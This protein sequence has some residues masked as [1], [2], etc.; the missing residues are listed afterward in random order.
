MC[1]I[2]YARAASHVKQWLKSDDEAI[3]KNSVLT[4][5]NESNA[6]VL[7]L[8]ICKTVAHIKYLRL[9][10]KNKKNRQYSGEKKGRKPLLSRLLFSDDL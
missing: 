1:I 4:V 10:E 5:L 2:A 8:N 7:V 3:T 9:T 6:E